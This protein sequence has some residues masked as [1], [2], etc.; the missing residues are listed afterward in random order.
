MEPIIWFWLIG[1]SLY[2]FV[3]TNSIPG[4]GSWDTY[5]ALSYFTPLFPRVRRPD[6]S[7]LVGLSVI[8]FPVVKFDF[9]PTRLIFAD[10][11]YAGYILYMVETYL[12]CKLYGQ[13]VVAIEF[14]CDSG[15]IC[16]SCLP[17]LRV[18]YS[19]LIIA[20]SCF[21]RATPVDRYMVF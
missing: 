21:E 3:P 7:P 8:R 16:H 14:I 15:P 12:D 18:C 20:M 17:T 5:P 4:P 13:K 2:H 19:P 11:R 1:Q 6:P 10:C 9:S